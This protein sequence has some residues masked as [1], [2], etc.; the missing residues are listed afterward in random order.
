V[1][2][3]FTQSIVCPILIGRRAH[4]DTL[5]QFME[6]AYRGHGQTVLISGEA[7]IGKSRL[8]AETIRHSRPSEVQAESQ[9]A[10]ILEGRCFEPDRALPYAPFLDLLRSFLSMQSPN[11]AAE[12]LGPNAAELVKLLP[13][14]ADHV[15]PLAPEAMLDPEQEKRRLFQALLRFFTRLSTFQ[16]LLV[17]IEDIH[18]SDDNSLEFLLFLARHLATHPILLLLTY[19]SEEDHQALLQFLAGLDRERITTELALSQLTI[20]EVE[21]LIR[22][23][24]GLPHT[25]SA[26]FVAAI[27]TSTEGNPFF[28][29]EMLKSL[30]A[31]GEIMYGEGKLERRSS[32][33]GTAQGVPM[34]N[35]PHLPRSTSLAI[36]QRL[37]H[38]SVEAR[39]VLSFAAVLGRRFD[40]AMLQYLTGRNEVD[41][42][43]LV[44]ELIAAQLLV[45]ESDDVLA[46]RHTLT[47][48]A[49]YADLLARER[50]SLHHSVAQ[51]MERLYAD[52]LDSHLGDIAY[53]YY[54]A[55]EWTK[56][57]AYAQRAGEKALALYA[58][59]AAIEH[60]THAVDAA[61]R[62]SLTPMI[63]LYRARGQCYEVLG[64]FTAARDDYLL[65][66][67]MA[68]NTHEQA[69]EWQSLLDLGYLWTRLD[70]VQAGDYLHRAL[71]L[72]RS[73]HDP[74]ILARTLNQVGNWL[75]NLEE[76]LKGLQ[77][78]REALSIF[79][80]SSDQHGLAETLDFLGV[81]S[82]MSGDLIASANYYEQAIAIFRALDDRQAL[83]SSLIFFAGRGG[84]YF[85][86]TVVSQTTNESAYLR[87]GEEALA[88]AQQLSLRSSQAFILIFLGLC[89][90]YRGEYG[91]ALSSGEKGLNIAIEFE[92]GLW[93]AGGYVL[94]GILSLELL[95]LVNAQ[96]YLERAYTLAKGSGS[97]YIMRV[98][99]A[100][101][102]TTYLFQG[103]HARAKSLLD[104][105]FGP[106][107]PSQTVAQRLVWCARAELEL[108]LACPDK[109]LTIIDQLISTA[110]NIE[111]G[112]VIPRL[113][114]LRSEALIALG[115][116][117]EACALLYSARD[118][119]Q[120]KGQR[121]LLWRIYV[122]LGKLYRA[123]ARLGQAEEA[124][125]MANTIIQELA[126]TVADEE[127]RRIF[128]HNA[129]AQLPTHPQPSPR[130]AAKQAFGGLTER[131]R[132]V[133]VLIA[134]GKSSRAIADELIVSERTI[135]KHVERI[136][137]RLGFTSR[138]QIA[139]WVVEKGLL[140]PSL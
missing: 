15:P 72:A 47:R 78:H 89:L 90:G 23:I 50:R 86:S 51:T 2:V 96:R 75:I 48:Q 57:L 45:E 52:E 46:F 102:A 128:L 13:E 34:P 130:T 53:H 29:E 67:E 104:D 122:T 17:I 4:L 11:E 1:V 18:W 129:S 95:D 19:R 137:S 85:A 37:H 39:E 93:I 127:L 62:L 83:I 135:E 139:T 88:L 117:D 61:Q 20:D 114:H 69:M 59:R 120:R 56:V 36:Q 10:L 74:L 28:I 42:V 94:L 64:D 92:H 101:F 3:P 60:Y 27:Y 124:S 68:Q 12:L 71:A 81:A 110:A 103:D 116:V 8:V 91:R 26:D 133:A 97:L 58:P 7:G 118:E 6:Q 16:P 5:I 115:R 106:E 9:A 131:E 126:N 111:D 138:V 63:G 40:F 136:M 77:Y 123:E 24:F 30:V 82:V 98:A 35:H 121:P 31:S 70:Y 41:L 54:M 49:A 140:K 79:Q 105:V 84:N 55:R 21:V 132:E 25:V 108:A 14:F 112:Q 76:P 100:Y 38:L 125:A 107:T 66:L 113:W 80:A 44:K 99:T 33:M 43:R 87:D 109:A 73:M 22:T 65:A 134:Q 119:A 32:E